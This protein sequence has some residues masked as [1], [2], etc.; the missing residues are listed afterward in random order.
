MAQ[1]GTTTIKPTAPIQMPNEQKWAREFNN[2]RQADA[3]AGALPQQNPNPNQEPQNLN[4]NLDIVDQNTGGLNQNLVRGISRMDT[5][6]IKDILKQT[7]EIAGQMVFREALKQSWYNLI[8][9]YGLTFLYINFHFIMAY[10]AQSR[11][12]CK[13]GVALSFGGKMDAVGKIDGGISETLSEYAEIIVMFLVDGL[14]IFILLLLAC[15]ISLIAWAVTNPAEF[16]TE[17]GGSAREI[18]NLLR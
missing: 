2:N 13:F 17:M 16:I 12:F 3:V 7:S 11:Y 5:G 8:D 14:I 9:S 1:G 18:I 6:S 4:P 10:L 15:F